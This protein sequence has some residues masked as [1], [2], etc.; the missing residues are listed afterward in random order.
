LGKKT[1]IEHRPIISSNHACTPLT[2]SYRYAKTYNRKIKIAGSHFNRSILVRVL[3]RLPHI[4]FALCTIIKIFILPV[5]DP[6]FSMTIFVFLYS[7]FRGLFAKFP[8]RVTSLL[9]C[10]GTTVRS[11]AL[12]LSSK[13]PKL[14]QD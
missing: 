5:L 9:V 1:Q 10:P 14:S 11:E 8:F 6:R 7:P 3:A 2:Q 13:L 4:L 12:I